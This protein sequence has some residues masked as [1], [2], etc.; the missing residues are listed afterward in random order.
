MVWLYFMSLASAGYGDPV[1]GLPAPSE[2]EI[3]MWTNAV[4]LDPQA[5]D[6]EYRRGGCSFSQFESDEKSPLQPL[7]WNSELNE[8]ARFHSEDMQDND[9]FSHT[10]YDGTPFSERISRFYTEG[11]VGE[12]IAWGYP[13]PF[14]A[15]MEGWMCSPGHRANIMT[16]GYNELGAGQDELYY[17]QNFGGRQGA[18]ERAILMGIHLPAN[19]SDTATFVADFMDLDGAR[20]EQFDVVVNGEAYP[21][22]L[23]WGASDMGVYTTD[24]ALNSASCHAYFFRT[25]VNGEETRFPEDGMYGWGDC[26]YNDYEAQWFAQQWFNESSEKNK[27]LQFGGCTSTAGLISAPA[28][29][30]TL[31]V[32]SLFFVRRRD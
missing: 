15:V 28:S 13:D 31:T 10:S 9:H 8:A 7:L 2:R 32:F 16:A 26:I 23:K 25:L 21:M 4:R 12:N 1:Q 19:P 5:F 29:L 11:Y 17:T 30:W 27:K 18:S 20:P 14:V 24:V 3:H 6:S 22:F